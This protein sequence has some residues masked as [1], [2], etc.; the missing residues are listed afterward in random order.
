M[1]AKCASGEAPHLG[2]GVQDSVGWSGERISGKGGA[3]SCLKAGKL[4][5]F[6]IQAGFN[7]KHLFLQDFLLK[8]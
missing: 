7:L 4:Q 6:S 5:S 8:H 3:G 1:G 2:G